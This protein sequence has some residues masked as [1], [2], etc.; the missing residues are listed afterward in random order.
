[1]EDTIVPQKVE[2]LVNSPFKSDWLWISIGSSWVN[3][4][5]HCLHTMGEIP[6]KH[7]GQTNI[8][9]SYSACV[10]DISFVQEPIQGGRGEVCLKSKKG[11]PKRYYI[12]NKMMTFREIPLCSW[13]RSLPLPH[14]SFGPPLGS[15][16]ILIQTMWHGQLSF[17]L[18]KW[19]SGCSTAYSVLCTEQSNIPEGWMHAYIKRKLEILI[20]NMYKTIDTMYIY[21]IF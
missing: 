11:F 1:M 12:Y 13:L 20:F 18:M 16:L 5:G 21:G 17:A 2:Y 7:A 19:K 8:V 10:C 4:L 3:T 9:Y 14:Q 15:P 6:A